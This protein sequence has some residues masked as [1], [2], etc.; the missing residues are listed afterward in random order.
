MYGLSFCRHKIMPL[1]VTC[2]GKGVKGPRK[3]FPKHSNE[4]GKMHFPL[5]KTFCT[6]NHSKKFWRTL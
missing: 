2:P 3:R 6:N 5:S 1:G 4:C